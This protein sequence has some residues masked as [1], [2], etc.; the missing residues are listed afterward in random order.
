M[1]RSAAGTGVAVGVFKGGLAVISPASTQK[2]RANRQSSFGPTYRRVSSPEAGPGA[3]IDTLEKGYPLLQYEGA[4]SMRLSL[5]VWRTNTRPRPVDGSRAATWPGETIPS[6]VSTVGPDPYG[7]VSD[8]S[9]SGPDLRAG[10]RISA[11]TDRTPG[12]GPGPL[13]VGFGP[14]SAGSWDF[15][16]ENTQALI[17]ARRGSGA[18]TCP[19]HTMYTSAP[20]SGGGPMLLRGISPVT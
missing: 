8:P 12:T 15:G 6:K 17:K 10:S 14:P 7:K 18:D 4:M 2:Q 5:V 11:G 16:A 9:I 1:G 13:C 3:T 19:G 20:R